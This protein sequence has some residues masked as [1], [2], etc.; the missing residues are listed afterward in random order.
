MLKASRA[1]YQRGVLYGDVE[2]WALGCA[3]SSVAVSSRFE[4]SWVSPVRR[5][6]HQEVRH[7]S[8]HV[9]YTDLAQ[10]VVLTVHLYLAPFSPHALLVSNDRS[11]PPPPPLSFLP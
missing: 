9:P 11:L 6:P 1:I 5:H 2:L 10:G 4:L 7:T 3:D 8:P